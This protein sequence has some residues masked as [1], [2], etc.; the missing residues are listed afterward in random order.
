MRAAILLLAV[1]LAHPAAAPVAV[2][3]WVAIMRPVELR[4]PSGKAVKLS[5]GTPARVL[6]V[7]DP[8][9]FVSLGKI[10]RVDRTAVLP[11]AEGLAQWE[12]AILKSPA[13]ATARFARGRILS[14]QLEYDKAI[15]DFDEGLRVVP[16]DSDALTLRGF[17]WKAKG[18]KDHAMA[19]LTRAIQLDPTNALAWRVR[20]A[21]WAAKA[22]YAKALADYDESIR[23]DPENPDS[24][25]HRVVMLSACKD[26]AIRNGKQAVADATRACELTEW[27]I[28]S[29]I[30]NLGIAYAE[31]G[32][33]AAAIK[34]HKRAMEL[35]TPDRAKAMEGRLEEYRQH[36]P[37]RMT[38]K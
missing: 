9:L 13:D 4:T 22:D 34:W 12:A 32:D 35:S 5:P 24:L 17:A 25:N 28:A 18:D 30:A 10:G 19:D 15:A 3:D 1:I 8:H 21:S 2:D 14:H 36:Q 26:P 33:F 20:G 38:W 6:A 16:D 31:A 23:V 11:L 7:E 37:F 27:R 29:Y